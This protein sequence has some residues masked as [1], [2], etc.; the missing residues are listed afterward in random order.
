ME[1]TDWN[2]AHN[3]KEQIE[4]D[5]PVFVHILGK[6]CFVTTS[7]SKLIEYNNWDNCLAMLVLSPEEVNT[8]TSLE[9]FEKSIEL[10]IKTIGDYPKNT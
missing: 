5:Y 6:A 10:F 8:I 9:W 3:I 2:H 4:K 7:D 1:I